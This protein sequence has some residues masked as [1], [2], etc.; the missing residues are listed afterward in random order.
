MQLFAHEHRLLWRRRT[1]TPLEEE[2]TDCSGGGHRLLWRRR[3][4][5]PLEEEEDTDSSGGGAVTVQQRS[6]LRSQI[7]TV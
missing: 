5:T 2:D 7:N 6:S 3:T 1:Q 4:Q